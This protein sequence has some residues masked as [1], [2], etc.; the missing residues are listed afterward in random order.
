MFT[1]KISNLDL[2]SQQ[3]RNSEFFILFRH[4]AQATR[5]CS[6]FANIKFIAL[7]KSSHCLSLWLISFLFQVTTVDKYQGQQNDIALVS[8]VR[9]R[10]VGHVRDL[11][12]LIVAASRARLGLYIFAR[13]NLFRNC[14]ELQPTFNQVTIIIFSIIRSD[15]I[16]SGKFLS[17]TS[18]IH[19]IHEFNNIIKP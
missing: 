4:P 10:A 8:L 13:A 14:F 19:V 2:H 12:R 15:I 17:P 18:K 11:R 6:I 3:S 7:S 16:I 9:T 5:F 1:H